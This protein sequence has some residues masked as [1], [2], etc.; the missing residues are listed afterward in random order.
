MEAKEIEEMKRSQKN[1]DPEY[2]QIRKVE[3]AF[4]KKLDFKVPQDLQ[5]IDVPV[6]FRGNSQLIHTL[7][8]GNPEAENLIT[9]HGIGASGLCFFKL[10]KELSHHYN[11]WSLDLLG[12]GASTRPLFIASQD[13]KDA[14]SF[15]IESIEEWRR[16]LKIEKATFLGHSFGGYL[17][18]LYAIRY[19]QHV[20]RVVMVSP[21][22]FSKTCTFRER[23]SMEMKI[24]LRHGILEKISFFLFKHRVSLPDLYKK[25]P[26]VMSQAI[27]YYL[28]KKLHFEDVELFDIFL[29]YCYAYFSLPEGSQSAL[30]SIL[31]SHRGDAYLTLEEL[32][33]KDKV[34]IPFDFYYGENDPLNYKGVERLVLKQKLNAAIFFIEDAGH[35]IIFENPQGLCRMMLAREE[36][37]Y[38]GAFGVMREKRTKIFTT[39]SDR[40]RP[41]GFLRPSL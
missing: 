16:E 37:A 26:N 20:N 38:K 9:I 34:D 22:G 23:V 32:L 31:S 11:I 4:F 21:A 18:G 7:H 41:L 24:G 39:K 19:P 1:I 28:Q 29:K 5:I 6:I 30:P 27:K 8:F 36:G 35:Q 12:Q 15:F 25:Y 33:E 13:P 10:F 2:A 3:K 40:F 14:I 17:A